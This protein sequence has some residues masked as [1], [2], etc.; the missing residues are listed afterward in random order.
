MRRIKNIAKRTIISL[1]RRFVALRTKFKPTATI[2]GWSWPLCAH[3]AA[4]TST[5]RL[6]FS[7]LRKSPSRRKT[8]TSESPLQ[9]NT[10]FSYTFARS[11]L[12]I[13]WRRRQGTVISHL[14]RKV[15]GGKSPNLTGVVM[16]AL[17]PNLSNH[18]SNTWM[19][20]FATRNRYSKKRK[21]F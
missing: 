2:L 6:A 18:Y 16:W 9:A 8:I 14:S 5:L 11:R 17:P 15:I 13:S 19:R 1:F 20:F 12:P 10:P 3:L 21:G 7:T 4:T